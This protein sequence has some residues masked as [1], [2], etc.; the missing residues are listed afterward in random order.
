MSI[1]TAIAATVSTASFAALIHYV[2]SAHFTPEAFVRRALVESG[3]SPTK[4]VYFGLAWIGVA[5]LIYGG[6]KSMLF[7]M[8]EDWGWADDDGDVQ[9][10]RTYVATGA[11]V[12]LT[13]PVL[14]FIH[15]AAAD[16]WDAMSR[17]QKIG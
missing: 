17:K 5:I 16:R 2:C 1:V 12:L 6:T 13:F 4:W 3:M 10:L 15:Q 7:W 8:P 11:A 14:G 9:S